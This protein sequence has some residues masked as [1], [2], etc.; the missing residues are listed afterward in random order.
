MLGGLHEAGPAQP[1][2][3]WLR[4]MSLLIDNRN[5]GTTTSSCRA[6]RPWRELAT[7]HSGGL[8]VSLYWLANADEVFVQVTDEQTGEIFVLEPPKSAALSAFYH[9]YALRPRDGVSS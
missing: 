9:P 5:T 8:T 6:H 4:A 1:Q 2:A 3:R 7:R